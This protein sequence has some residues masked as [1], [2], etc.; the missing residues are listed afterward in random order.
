MLRWKQYITIDLTDDTN[1]VVK[2]KHGGRVIEDTA[3][4]TVR[5]DNREIIGFGKDCQC[6]PGIECIVRPPIVMGGIVVD[7]AGWC[8]YI[9]HLISEVMSGI[10][11][12][13][14]RLSSAEV[15]VKGPLSEI[16][17][18]ALVDAIRFAGV[19]NVYVSSDNGFY[20]CHAEKKTMDEDIVQL[21]E[22]DDSLREN[23]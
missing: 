3:V 10:R 15:L 19:R 5:K 7:F 21:V 22:T 11:F 13:R 20:S 18:R 14:L 23:S 1:N 4:I 2:I 16:E 6:P 8:A 12:W 9:E 17:H